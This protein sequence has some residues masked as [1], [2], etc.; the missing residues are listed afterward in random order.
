MRGSFCP[1][2][3]ETLETLQSKAESVREAGFDLVV[4]SADLPD[5]AEAWY[6]VRCVRVLL[7]WWWWRW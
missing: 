4:L 7:G 3:K 5:A 6:K 2:C 1:I